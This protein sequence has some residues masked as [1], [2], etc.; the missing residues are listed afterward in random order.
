MSHNPRVTA[1]RDHSS[2]VVIP[3][4][5]AIEPGQDSTK[6]SLSSL[7]ISNKLVLQN[8]VML[9]RWLLGDCII[10]GKLTKKSAVN[11]TAGREQMVAVSGLCTEGEEMVGGRS[12]VRLWVN[13]FHG[14]TCNPTHNGNILGSSVLTCWPTDNVNRWT[15]FF[16]FFFFIRPLYVQHTESLHNSLLQDSNSQSIN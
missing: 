7:L 6:Q 13:S 15:I 14:G 8:I 2:S 12:V 16:F 4:L 9:L 5:E 3:C 11:S 10:N 1:A